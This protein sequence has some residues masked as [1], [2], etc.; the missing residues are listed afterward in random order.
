MLVQRGSNY[1]N[2]MLE[3]LCKDKVYI[4]IKIMNMPG[5]EIK[6]STLY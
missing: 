2:K 6:C 1:R 4:R 5:Q 3:Y